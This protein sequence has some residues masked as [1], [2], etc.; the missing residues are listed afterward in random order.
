MASHPSTPPG[1]S[2]A[3]G[4]S[5]PGESP[6]PPG[7]SATADVAS[8]PTSATEGQDHPASGSTVLPRR[9][10]GVLVGVALAAVVAAGGATLTACRP[11]PSWRAYERLEHGLSLEA[12]SRWW[13]DEQ[14]DR[15]HVTAF[16]VRRW[17]ELD[18]GRLDDAASR[19]AGWDVST[20]LCSSVPDRGPSFD[21]R[22]PCVRHDFAW[23]NIRR[24]AADRAVVRQARHRA[25]ARF[26]ADLRG[27]C[28]ARPAPERVRC[29]A[30]ALA[31]FLGVELVA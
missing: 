9:L 18:P 7:A 4:P 8:P 27:R 29:R 11:H 12:F 23:R 6:V 10:R 24:L 5:A 26:L 16:Q 28:A 30:V 3:P 22:W 19:A 25:D 31:Y 21:F 1:W 17:F 2:A 14:A 20:D 15:H 13:I